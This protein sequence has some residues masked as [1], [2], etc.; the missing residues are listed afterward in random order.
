M[1]PYD[2]LTTW[3]NSAYSM[4]QSLLEVLDN[5]AKDSEDFPEIRAQ[6]Q[7]HREETRLHAERVKQCL[8]RLNEE[9]SSVKSAWGH[10]TGMIQGAS[11]GAFRDELV[12]NFLADYAA[13]QFEVACYRSLVAAAEELGQPAIAELCRDNLREDEAMALW[14]DEKIPE[15]TRTFLQRQTATA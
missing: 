6:I 1:S 4:E 3:L 11:T 5:H 10:L 14:L 13:E 9:P 15:V 12:K 2:Q 8:T 7:R